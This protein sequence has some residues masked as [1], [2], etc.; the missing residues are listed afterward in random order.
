MQCSV[1]NTGKFTSWTSVS[2]SVLLT[3][4]SECLPALSAFIGFWPAV[5]VLCRSAANPIAK[6]GGFCSPWRIMVN[7]QS[8]AGEVI[9]GSSL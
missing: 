9:G 8:I 1:E 3:D 4:I 6:A 7:G 2:F 5:S